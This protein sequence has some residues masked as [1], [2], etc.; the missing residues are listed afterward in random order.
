VGSPEERAAV[1]A[2]LRDY[3]E[4]WFD[5]STER[6][7]RSLHPDLVKRRGS[8]AT[9]TDIPRTS[10]AQ[11]MELTANGKGAADRGDGRLE[12]R[13]E[14]IHGRI[15]NATVRG[16]IYREYVQLIKTDAVWKIADTLWD[17]ELEA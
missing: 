17:T 16:G 7:D 5:G 15:A 12:I 3:F 11:M 2:V 1:E 14:D 6:M 10:K 4:G 8:S 9:E 13:I